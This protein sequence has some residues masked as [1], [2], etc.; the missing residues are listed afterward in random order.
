MSVEA[1]PG[2]MIK[3]PW[4]DLIMSGKKTWEIRG[5]K[6]NKRGFIGLIPSKSGHV[7]GVA[8]LVNVVGPLTLEQY[9]QHQ[10]KHQIPQEH[11]TKLPYKKTYAW[12]LQDPKQL[13]TPVPYVHPQ[14][15]V[16]WV[17]LS[18][19]VSAKARSQLT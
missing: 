14:G 2:L 3:R 9:Q 11:L 8:R 18:Q 12:V 19:E 13:E 6:T 4:V 10:P 5:S 17:R 16:I 7:E 15:A 1:F